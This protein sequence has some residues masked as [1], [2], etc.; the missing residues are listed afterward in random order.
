MNKRDRML[1]R[2]RKHG[3]SLLAAFPDAVEEDPDRLCRALRRIEVKI[4]AMAEQVCNGTAD[5]DAWERASDAALAKVRGILRPSGALS[6]ALE[7]NG[8]PRGYALKISDS[9][10]RNLRIHRDWGGYGILAPDL[11]QD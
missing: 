1:E 7:I 4:H 6:D 9:A 5:Y 2:I 11:S 3:K 8:D 10:V